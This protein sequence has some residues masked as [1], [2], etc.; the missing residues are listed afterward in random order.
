MLKLALVLAQF[1]RSSAFRG[2]RA[3]VIVYIFA[4]LHTNLRT[5][6]NMWDINWLQ[7][8]VVQSPIKLTQ[9]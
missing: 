1:N 9:D 7:G 2:I 5:E 6:G 4:Y 3:D 8:R